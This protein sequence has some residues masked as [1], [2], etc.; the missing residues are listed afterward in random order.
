[1]EGV[2][3]ASITSVLA[4]IGVLITCITSNRKI[5][6]KLSISQAVIDTKIDNLTEEVRK[7]NNFAT[8]MP[9]VEEQIKTLTH[10]VDELEHEK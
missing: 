3:S 8:R 1:M 5:E 7:H 2:I 4:L 10:R 9:V 6:T